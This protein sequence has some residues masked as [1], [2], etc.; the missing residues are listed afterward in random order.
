[1][2]FIKKFVPGMLR[3]SEVGQFFLQDFYLFVDQDSNP[4]DESVFMK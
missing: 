2:I 4:S 3:V 1:M